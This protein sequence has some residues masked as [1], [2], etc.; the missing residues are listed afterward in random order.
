MSTQS[1]FPSGAFSGSDDPAST[2]KPISPMAVTS[3]VL[4]VV[5]LGAFF[6]GVFWIVPPIAV[7]VAGLT[8]YR[9]EQAREE[10]AG[11]FAAKFGALLAVIALC[12]APTIYFTKRYIL[13]RESRAVA[14]SF[15]DLI[16]ENK[17]K[18]AFA[19][20]ARPDMQASA[21]DDADRILDRMGREPYQMF[22]GSQP[23]ALFGGK[24][25]NVQVTHSGLWYVGDEKGV[26]RVVHVYIVTVFN[27]KNEQDGLFTFPVILSGAISPEWAGRKWMIENYHAEPYDPKKPKASLATFGG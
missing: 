13:G 14:D 11:Q 15:V 1:P 6:S 18:M 7:V 22:L 8:S 4:G 3:L 24:G 23:V 9:L 26:E 10:Y 17:L 27:D 2:Y 25:E 20:T 21:N 16:L 19:K 5:S 12:G